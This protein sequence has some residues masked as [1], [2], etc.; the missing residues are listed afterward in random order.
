MLVGAGERVNERRRE[1]VGTAGDGGR[2]RETAGDGG[3][4]RET[5]RWPFVILS[6]AK[7]LKARLEIL[8]SLRSLRMTVD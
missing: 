8:R 7:D 6:E 4:R 5:A 2:R 3:G 1:T